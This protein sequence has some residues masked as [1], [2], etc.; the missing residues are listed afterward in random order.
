MKSNRTIAEFNAAAMLLGG[1]WY[2]DPADHTFTLA[3]RHG[4]T[5]QE[6][7]ADTLAPLNVLDASRYGRVKRGEIGAADYDG[8]ER[9]DD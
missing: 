9:P 4:G 6:M 7:D 1:G 8:K 5:P 2:Y 3:S